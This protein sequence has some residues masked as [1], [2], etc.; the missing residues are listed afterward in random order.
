MVCNNCC[1]SVFVLIEYTF[2]V[3]L[4]EAFLRGILHGFK[5]TSELHKPI[6]RV[7]NIITAQ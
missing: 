2:A 1:F 4:G 3:V 7:K 5:P 6:A